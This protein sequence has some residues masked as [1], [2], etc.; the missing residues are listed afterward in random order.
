MMIAV[1]AHGGDYAPRE[2]VKGAIEA[3]EDYKVDI[4]LVGRKAILQKLARSNGRKS[5]LTFIDATQTIGYKEDPF[6][7]ISSKPDSS[8]VVGTNLVRDGIASAF[9]SAGN[10]GAVVVAAFL[11]LGRIEGVQRIAVS[12]LYGIDTPN[13]IL[14]VDVGV[15]VDCRPSFLVQFAQLGTIFSREVLGV[16]S[17]RVGLLNNGEEETKGN[18]LTK[19]TYQLLKKA[20]LNFIGNIEGQEVLKGKAD[21]IVADG[22]TGNMV[23]KTIEGLG[24]TF[25]DLLAIGEA[26]GIDRQLTGSAL[27]HYMEMAATAKQVDYQ[28]VGGGC[29]L[30]V[31]GNVIIAHGRSKARAIKNAIHLAHRA[32]RAGV[33]ETLKNG[34]YVST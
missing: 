2:V 26:I 8:I 24:S 23:I 16:S 10:T 18:L 34:Q 31:N 33:V 19:D 14:L 29:L 17:P 7:A 25:Q 9:V 3:A 32:A 12:A 5:N 13:Q 6:E 28:E 30:G 4:A 20:D 22:F 11:T 21:V 1:D 27:V 15:N